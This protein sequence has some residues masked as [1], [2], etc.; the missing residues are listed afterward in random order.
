MD[1]KSLNRFD[2]QVKHVINAQALKLRVKLETV[3]SLRPISQ[4]DWLAQY[5]EPGQSFREFLSWNPWLGKRKRS[6]YRGGDFNPVSGSIR[7]RY[8]SGKMY[9]AQ[10]GDFGSNAAVAP[11]FDS[12]R[13]LIMI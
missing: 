7:E 11:D 13:S 1:I 10:I 6:S 3:P 4:D 9:L 8:P 2:L 5:C 12:V